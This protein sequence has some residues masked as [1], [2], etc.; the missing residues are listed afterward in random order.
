MNTKN[1]TLR[2]L[3]LLQSICARRD[4]VVVI[5]KPAQ[6]SF[7]SY[8]SPCWDRLFLAL[9]CMKNSATHLLRN[10][11]RTLFKLFLNRNPLQNLSFLFYQHQRMPSHKYSWASVI[12][13]L[14]WDLFRSPRSALT[15][16][17]VAISQIYDY[18]R[19]KATSRHWLPENELVAKFVCWFLCLI[20]KKT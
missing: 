10:H 13:S 6:T 11:T 2:S 9:T 8:F 18:A 17:P 4:E 5:G 15:S 1:K 16:A 14:W 12:Q 19:S 7:K 3:H 20:W